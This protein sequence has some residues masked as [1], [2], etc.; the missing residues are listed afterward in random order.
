MIYYPYGFSFVF[1]WIHDHR[2]YEYFQCFHGRTSAIRQWRLCPCL[3]VQARLNDEVK[4]SKNLVST[5][6]TGELFNINNE[7]CLFIGQYD[8]YTKPSTN[9]RHGSP[10]S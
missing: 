9:F 2:I 5:G 8:N 6:Q 1:A 3:F 10:G 4:N 7:I